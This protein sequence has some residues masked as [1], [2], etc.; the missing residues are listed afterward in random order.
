MVQAGET[1]PLSTSSIY[2]RYSLTQCSHLQLSTEECFMQTTHASVVCL[3][4][5][6]SLPQV[7][8]SVMRRFQRRIFRK[9]DFDELSSFGCLTS[10]S[11]GS[12]CQYHVRIMRDGSSNLNAFASQPSRRTFFCSR[13][14]LAE[15]AA[16][17]AL[18]E[19]PPLLVGRPVKFLVPFPMFP[20]RCFNTHPSRVRSSSPGDAMP[21]LEMKSSTPT[22]SNCRD[23]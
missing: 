8:K 3:R 22:S 16:S 21:G 5:R 23:G 14:L 7:L 4:G 1:R 19:R 12:A 17:L 18:F 13:P 11:R 2:P 6:W 9:S 10:A 15:I 20:V